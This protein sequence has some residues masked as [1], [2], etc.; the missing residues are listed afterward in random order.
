MHP[1]P[2]ESAP[3][4]GGRVAPGFAVLE[5]VALWWLYFGTPA[6]PLHAA[7][8]ASD[9]PGRVARDAYTYLHLLIIA[10]IVATAAG[11]ELLIAEPHDAPHDMGLA[12]V[13]GGPA[14]FLLGESLFQW[15]TTGRANAKR[16]VAAALIIGLVPLAPHVP[17]LAL[18][19]I[20][21]V[22]L[23]IL[24]LWEL[25]ASPPPA[26]ASRQRAVGA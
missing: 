15:M 10:G 7:M 23:T 4:Y 8:T 19:V 2:V 16:L 13:L 6:E 26:W 9:D 21:T 14:L 1:E 20:V 5:T 25:R 12:I 11:N 3:H 17:V 22:L 24:A 18:A